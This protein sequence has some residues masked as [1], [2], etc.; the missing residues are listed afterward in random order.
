MAIEN[1][2]RQMIQDVI[3]EIMDDE[4]L[5][6]MS[7]VNG[8]AGGDSYQTP[9]AFV[10]K[11]SGRNR[12]KKWHSVITRKLG[13]EPVNDEEEADN[14][15]ENV[16]IGD[17][18]KIITSRTAGAKPYEIIVDKIIN[19]NTVRGVINSGPL[20]GTKATGKISES[21]RTNNQE[22]MNAEAKPVFMGTKKNKDNKERWMK[23][24]TKDD[25]VLLHGILEPSDEL[26]NVDFNPPS[27]LHFKKMIVEGRNG[28][29]QN[30]RDDERTPRQK[31]GTSLKEM[32]DQLREIEKNID[33]NLRLKQ[34]TGINSK[35]YWKRTHR[36]LGRIGESMHRIQMKLRKFEE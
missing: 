24:I 26:E 9:M 15:E 7:T 30:Y 22:Y 17:K 13:Y 12:K 20:A 18:L 19:K 2:L 36:A 4:E 29:Y 16:K 6:E 32:R 8:M 5:D 3:K 23:E 10:G 21:T 27:K 33:L 11:G 34:E 25:W 1:F 28:Q 14:L 31:I 35:Q